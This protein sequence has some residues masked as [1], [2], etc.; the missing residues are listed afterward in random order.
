M[1]NKQMVCKRFVNSVSFSSL[2]PPNPSI[3]PY[4]SPF[5]SLDDD[6]DS[7]TETTQRKQ[8][9][10]HVVWEGK[11]HDRAFNDWKVRHF[12]TEGLARDHLKRHGVEHYWDLA[13]SETIVEQEED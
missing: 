10:C 12:S 3:C 4:L 5:P 8:N 11:V 1:K 9:A 6:D 13:L 7:D 2:P